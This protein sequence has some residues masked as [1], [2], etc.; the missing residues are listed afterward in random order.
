MNV[1]IK[2]SVSKER[3]STHFLGHTADVHSASIWEPDRAYLPIAEKFR[4]LRRSLGQPVHVAFTSAV[5]GEGVSYIVQNLRRELS[6]GQGNG[7]AVTIAA[8]D[9]RDDIGFLPLMEDE[10]E[11][12]DVTQELW[13]PDFSEPREKSGGY[14]LPKQL[15]GLGRR[16]DYILVDCP[17]LKKSSDVLIVGK[18]CLGVCLV[19]AAGKTTRAQIQGAI[20]MLAL[21]G[22]PLI[23][24][25]LNKRTYPIPEFVYKFL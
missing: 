6:A 22:I 11:D 7:R 15:S 20:S 18:H 23:G 21:S 24:C 12:A 16:F 5:P 19:V 13:I 2:S 1:R 9:L 17:S 4:E 14:A 25:V 3:A 10:E 8:S